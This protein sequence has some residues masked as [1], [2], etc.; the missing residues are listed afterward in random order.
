MRPFTIRVVSPVLRHVAGWL[1]GFCIATY[2]G[3]T[4]GRI[5]RTPLNVFLRGSRAVFALTYGEDIQWVRNVV[6]ADGCDIRT[7]G[8]RKRARAVS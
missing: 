1:P 6:A 7:R 8:K 4:S 3:R 2:R 5:Y